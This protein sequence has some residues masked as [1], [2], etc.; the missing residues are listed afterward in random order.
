MIPNQNGVSDPS[1][2][3]ANGQLNGEGDPATQ[4]TTAHPWEFVDEISNVLKTTTP[5]LHPS[6]EL[7]A[8]NIIG[9]FKPTPEEEIYR[10]ILALLSEALHVCIVGST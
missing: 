2:P 8:E 3:S 7:V 10:F 9:R 5:L 6:L 1:N 4:R